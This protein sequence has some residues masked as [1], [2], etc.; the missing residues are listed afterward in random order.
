M[1]I[2]HRTTKF[3]RAFSLSL[4]SSP[5]SHFRQ[6]RESSIPDISLPIYPQ[7]NPIFHN[8]KIKYLDSIDSASFVNC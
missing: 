6:E 2:H 1:K 7:K 5:L 3:K 4:I 8:L